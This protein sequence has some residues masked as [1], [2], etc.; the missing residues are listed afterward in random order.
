MKNFEQPY[1]VWL[2]MITEKVQWA[3]AQIGRLQ[4]ELESMKQM[5]DAWACTS[6]PGGMKTRGVH[7]V[8]GEGAGSITK[9]TKNVGSCGAGTGHRWC[10]GMEDCGK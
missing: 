1:E 4:A 9:D 5:R 10:D 8:A 2:A 7:W 6:F 3:D